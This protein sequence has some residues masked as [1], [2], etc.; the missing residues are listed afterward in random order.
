MHIIRDAVFED[1]DGVYALITELEECE[2][3]RRD[4]SDIFKANLLSKQICYFVAEEEG[5]L[6]G[7]ASVYFQRLLHH[8]A[9]IAE[10]Q[11]LVVTNDSRGLGLG[12][13]LLDKAAEKA[14]LE[15]CPQLEVSCGKKRIASHAFYESQGLTNNHYKFCLKL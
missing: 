13:Q 2:L 6:I 11:E 10:L 9:K 5:R 15:N 7:F 1:E 4:F 3:P 8:A 14:R 12:K